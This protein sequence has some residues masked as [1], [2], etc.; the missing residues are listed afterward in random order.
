[1]SNHPNLPAFSLACDNLREDKFREVL[2]QTEYAKE[3]VGAY[4]SKLNSEGNLSLL[5]IFAPRLEV[6][7]SFAEALGEHATLEPLEP[8]SADQR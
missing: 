2:G 6:A 8:P 1:M 3:G 5:T 7:Q 4:M